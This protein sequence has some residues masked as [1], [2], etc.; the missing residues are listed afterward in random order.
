VS[1]LPAYLDTSAIVKL[2]SPEAETDALIAA[3]AA[4]PDRVTSC[5]ARTEV[6]RALWRARASRAVRTRAEAV[7]SGLVLVRLD[8]AV[9]ARASAFRDPA[10]RSLDAL[11]LAA[12]L[13]L[14]DY[15]EAFVTYD[16]RLA[17]AA[18]RQRLSVRHPGVDAL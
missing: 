17:R 11:H 8:D 13:S 7:L 4:W 3:I 14:G 1:F 5:L 18:R 2:V 15:P 6:H 12:A 16:A 10:L 9:I